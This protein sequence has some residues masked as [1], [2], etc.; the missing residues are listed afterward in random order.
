[1]EYQIILKH[2]DKTYR[3]SKLVAAGDGSLYWYFP[4]SQKYYVRAVKVVKWRPGKSK[5]K[6]EGRHRFCSDPYV[7]FHPGKGI[8]HAKGKSKLGQSI[9][10]VEDSEQISFDK[11]AL[12]LS[13]QV[14]FSFVVPSKLNVLDEY[15]KIVCLV[16]DLVFKSDK[17]EIDTSLNFEFFV[18]NSG[19]VVDIDDLK[20]RTNRNIIAVKEIQ[21]RNCYFTIT[22]VVS[23]IRIVNSKDL[24]CE[25]PRGAKIEPVFF[26][27]RKN[28]KNND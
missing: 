4:N 24:V 22:C 26:A 7:S 19:G 28:P 16:S 12:A 9:N 11:L 10:L 23:S 21:L 17:E 2:K 1:M 20:A 13:H 15:N 6:L 5:I 3:V 8:I 25:I 27:L 18:H 14:I